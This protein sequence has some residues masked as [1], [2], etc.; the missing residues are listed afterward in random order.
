MGVNNVYSATK[1]GFRVYVWNPKLPASRASARRTAT[2]PGRVR[3]VVTSAASG[4][5]VCPILSETLD[6][7]SQARPTDCQVSP[8]SASAT[9]L[10][11]TPFAHDGKKNF[12]LYD[13]CCR[14]VVWY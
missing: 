11:N 9:G 7:K 5:S 10:K 4:G 3:A 13:A 6:C 2:C 1:N 12:Y 8:W 14:L